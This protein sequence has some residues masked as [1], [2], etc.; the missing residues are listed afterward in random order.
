M[1]NQN[2]YVEFHVLQTVPPSCVN[3]DDTGSPKTAVY[4]GATRARVSSQAWKRAIR[5]MFKEEFPTEAMGVRTK[6]LVKV[7]SEQITKYDPEANAEEL[8]KKVLE[9]AGVTLKKIKDGKEETDALFFIS[10]GQIDALARFA[11]EH[12]E[13]KYG[14]EEKDACIKALQ[15]HP[16]IDL[17]LF[18]RM[19]AGQK[20][21]N[22]DAA[23]QVA[24][25]ISTHAVHNE[26]DYFTALDEQ[27]MEDNAGA[28]HMGTLEYNSA[29]LYRYANVNVCELQKHL[30][31]DTAKAVR[32]FADAFIRSMPTGKQNSY[33]NRTLPSM[34]YVTVRDD[35]PINLSEAFERPVSAGKDGYVGASV[36]VLSAYAE[37]IY[38]TFVT[39]PIESYVVGKNLNNLAEKMTLS[40][41]LDKLEEKIKK[42]I[43]NDE[44]TV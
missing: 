32:G 26:Y 29:T 43:S 16:S 37:E 24:H 14:K 38:S 23:A 12:P 22:Y 41:M 42:D 2:M 31:T 9:E 19:V 39:K 6:K 33:A 27:A 8:A 17:A 36:A 20:S 21:M 1:K 40:Q 13:D 44:V 7:V 4:G 25:A 15:K 10:N 28:G 30:G 34:V 5:K 11:L 35:Q 18:G 3:R